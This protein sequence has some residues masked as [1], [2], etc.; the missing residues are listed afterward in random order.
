MHTDNSESIEIGLR[1]DAD[2]CVT[3]EVVALT[4]PLAPSFAPISVL[5]N[6]ET[7]FVVG[8]CRWRMIAK[9]CCVISK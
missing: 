8:N 1:D 6:S 3:I 9:R 4:L 2:C 7:L 5:C